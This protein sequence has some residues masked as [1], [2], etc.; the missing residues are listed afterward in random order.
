MT[1]SSIDRFDVSAYLEKF[2]PRRVQG[3]ELVLCCPNCGKDKL[4][5]NTQRRTWHC[6]VCEEFAVD[7][8][9]GRRHAVRGAGGL[10]ALIAML[11]GIGREQ[12]AELVRT[13]GG[14][15]GEEAWMRGGQLEQ[16][17]QSFEF[18][19]LPMI[20]PPEGATPIHGTLPYLQKRGILEED[21]RLFGL[22]WCASG[23][24]ANRVVFPVY[25]TGRMVYYQARAMWEPHPG[26]RFF[27]KA[28]NPPAVQGVAT[29][30]E[31]LMNLDAAKNFPRVAI[32]EGP[33]DCIH[34]GPSAVATFGKKISLVQMLKLRQA[35]VR[36]V[37]LMWDG[38]S[39]SE[40]EGAWPE[41][42][43]AAPKLAGLFDVR[44]VRLP[45]GDP[46]EYSRGALETFRAQARPV[47][48]VS[49]LESL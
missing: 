18:P 37:D 16:L 14:L 40:P 15:L 12:A 20:P 42:V 10:L 27:Q 38:P 33:V 22:F 7:Y 49:R 3:D 13:H 41:M 34:A 43:A 21:V 4:T 26:E 35:G 23:R 29:A 17:P 1:W 36:A 32:V 24:Y 46:G 25:D 2:S 30:G 45:Q 39:A 44:L 8:Q 48:A 11:E 31:V 19:T 47:G 9:T 5:V 28:L 6:W